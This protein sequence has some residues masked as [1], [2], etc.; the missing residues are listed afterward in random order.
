MPTS[1]AGATRRWCAE[2]RRLLAE[3]PLRE[4]LWALLM[5]ALYGSGRAAEALGAYAQAREVIA[6]ELGADPSAELQQ[7]HEQML[8]SGTGSGPQFSATKTAAADSPFT[9]PAISGSGR[10]P[11]PRCGRDGFRGGGARPTASGPGSAAAGPPP[12]VT[13]YVPSVV[14]SQV[15]QLPADIPDFTGRA[16]HV[17]KL[18]DLL[19]GPGRPDSPGAVVVAAVIGAGGLGKTT[20]AVHAA[21][22]LRSHFP[23]GQLYANLRG[24]SAQLV[25][26]GDVL[27]RFLRD[28]GMDP[29]GFPRARKNERRSSAAG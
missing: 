19:A 13:G 29:D 8:R 3:H 23:D 16:E 12:P 20:L 10:D 4:G 25:P 14:L 7:L 11:A 26:P 2:L 28:L 1:A 17:Q 24:A 27:A 21:H 22:L 6:E 9:G 15:A 5:R 18:H